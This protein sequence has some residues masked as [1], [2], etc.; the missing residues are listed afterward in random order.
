[1]QATRAT[2]LA[3]NRHLFALWPIDTTGVPWVA[4]ANTTET[5]E[6]AANHAVFANGQDEVF[7]ARRM[8][9]A[10]TSDDV[11]E[12]DLIQPHHRDEEGRWKLPQESQ[13]R[14]DGSLVG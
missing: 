8:E 13:Q 9:T 12:C 3:L 10:L 4:A 7:T 14:H 5:F 2:G 1:M 6:E 11:A